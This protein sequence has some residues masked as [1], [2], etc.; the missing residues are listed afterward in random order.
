MEQFEHHFRKKD[1]DGCVTNHK[2]DW[3]HFQEKVIVP[4]QLVFYVADS[5]TEMYICMV[6]TFQKYIAERMVKSNA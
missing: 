1:F 2:P 6:Q 5:P 4:S 3:H